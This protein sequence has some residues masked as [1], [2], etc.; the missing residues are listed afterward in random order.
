MGIRG[1][2]NSLLQSVDKQSAPPAPLPQSTPVEV[3][4][5]FTDFTLADILKYTSSMVAAAQTTRTMAR[6]SQRLLDIAFYE[7]DISEQDRNS[8]AVLYESVVQDIEQSLVNHPEGL[9]AFKSAQEMHFETLRNFGR[10]SLCWMIATPGL[11]DEEILK[12]VIDPANGQL[13]PRFIN[14]APDVWSS[15]KARALK[16]LILD[17]QRSGESNSVFILAGLVAVSDPVAFNALTFAEKSALINASMDYCSARQVLVNYKL[18]PDVSSALPFEP[19]VDSGVIAQIAA[20]SVKG[21]DEE[22]PWN[23]SALSAHPEFNGDQ[24]TVIGVV[25]IALRIYVWLETIEGLYGKAYASNVEESFKNM[26]SSSWSD[27]EHIIE[28]IH[29]SKIE[30]SKEEATVGWDSMIAIGYMEAYMPND[31]TVS[32]ETNM[33]LYHAATKIYNA[34]HVYWMNKDRFLLRY[35]VNDIEK[36]QD[37]FHLTDEE[38]DT[39]MALGA[40]AGNI[41]AKSLYEDWIGTNK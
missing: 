6:L 9:A 3:P 20:L 18:L 2:F 36:R 10:G 11:T 28:V 5:D 29:R 17:R 4:E 8:A 21:D 13:L 33:A 34:E 40:F 15:F 7:R 41:E 22:S 37:R 38:Q 35:F 23:D 30:S 19:R 32:E 16:M 25:L 39:Y 1:F 14:S 26:L 31:D 12:M 24:K 27:L